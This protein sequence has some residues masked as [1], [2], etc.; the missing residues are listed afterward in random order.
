MPK[1]EKY[2]GHRDPVTHLKRYYNQLTGADEKEELLMAYFGKN[3][4]GIASERNSLSNMKKKTAESFREYTVKWREKAAMVK[5]PMDEIEMVMA[6]VAIGETEEKPK[7]GRQT[8][9]FPIRPES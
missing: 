9:M 4:T 3:L 5:P 7:N 6:I 8:W 1:F 2:N